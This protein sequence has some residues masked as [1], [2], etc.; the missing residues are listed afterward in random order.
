M[1]FMQTIFMLYFYRFQ[2]FLYFLSFQLMKFLLLKFGI[3]FQL[4]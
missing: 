3:Q 2:S 4:F 1:H